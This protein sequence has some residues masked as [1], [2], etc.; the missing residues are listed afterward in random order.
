MLR[1]LRRFFS[2]RTVP[3]IVISYERAVIWPV[4]TIMLVM[5]L[6]TIMLVMTLMVEMLVVALMYSWI[7]RSLKVRLRVAVTPVT[8]ATSIRT[9]R[10]GHGNEPRNKQETCQYD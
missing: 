8:G 3:I 7:G 5:V 4:M 2:W 10:P 9:M 6:M 1:N